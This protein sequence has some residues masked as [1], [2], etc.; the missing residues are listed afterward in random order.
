MMLEEFIDFV[1]SQMA[2]HE[3]QVTRHEK[4]PRR[5]KLHIETADKFSG[6]LEYLIGNQQTDDQKA[7]AKGRLSLSWE[8]LEDLPEELKAELSITDS[9]KLDFT[10]ES[11]IK[12]SGGIATLDRILVDLYRKTGEVHK[13]QSLN[14]R[15]YRMAQK[16]MIYSVP[17]KKGVYSSA[18]MSDEEVN[19][20]N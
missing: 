20:L 12:Q 3:R 18:P 5:Q 4:D 15:L 1:K 19:E 10:I 8:E 16:S 13:R 2:F 7:K 14:A 11:I 17:N 6:L 9:D